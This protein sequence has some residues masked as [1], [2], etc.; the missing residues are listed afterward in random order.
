MTATDTPTQDTAESTQDATETATEPVQDP[1][2]QEPSKAG[3]ERSRANAEAAKYRVRAK[4]AET[5]LGVLQ[6]RYDNLLKATISDRLPGNVPAPVFWKFVND[7]LQ[8]I[9]EDGN[10]DSERVA[11]RAQEVW[12]ESGLANHQGP[13][14][15]YV[16]DIDKTPE[17]PRHTTW[18][19]I[20]K[21]Q[22]DD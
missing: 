22:V 14:G 8:F 11:A 7:P 17:P 3:Q 13:R 6:E 4:E 18:D 12:K 1:T 9:G 19:T 15:P 10:V 16:P 5:A 21:G 20:L 2:P